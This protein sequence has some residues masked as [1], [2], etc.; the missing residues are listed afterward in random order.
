MS[1]KRKDRPDLLLGLTFSEAL[2]RFTKTD[3][4]ELEDAFAQTMRE[5]EEAKRYVDERRASIRKG[6][7]RAPKRFRI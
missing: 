2:E 5:N 1:A 4:K 6:A 7:R 3:P